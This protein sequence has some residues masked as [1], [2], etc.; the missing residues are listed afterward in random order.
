MRG[1]KLNQKELEQLANHLSDLSHL[2]DD[3]STCSDEDSD[4]V[5]SNN[6]K[7]NGE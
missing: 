2:D 4:Y 3:L 7:E 6:G 1:Q 5:P